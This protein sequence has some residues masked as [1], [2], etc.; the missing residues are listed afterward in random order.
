[1]RVSICITRYLSKW[2]PEV[3]VEKVFAFTDRRAG[4]LMTPRPNGNAQRNTGFIFYGLK[5]KLSSLLPNPRFM[6][7]SQP[8]LET[9]AKLLY[10]REVARCGCPGCHQGNCILRLSAWFCSIRAANLAF[11]PATS[12]LW[13]FLSLKLE[14]SGLMCRIS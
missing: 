10:F 2:R 14:V 1:M 12:L 8:Y 11:R 4:G 5:G 9:K 3:V 7:L 13:D 6:Y